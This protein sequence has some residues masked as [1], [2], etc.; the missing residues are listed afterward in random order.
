MENSIDLTTVPATVETFCQPEE[1]VHHDYSPSTLQSLEACPCWIGKQSENPHPRTVIGTL[2]HTVTETGEDD[3]KLADEDIEKVA[4]CIDFFESRKRL[5]IEA[6]ERSGLT[7]AAVTEIKE[8]YLP[9]DD[10]EFTD[11]DKKV[12]ATTAG[13][14]DCGI[15]THDKT[16]GEFFDWKFGMWPVE[17]AENNL[18]GIAYVLGAFRMF[19]Q[20]QTVRFWFKQPNIGVL[21]SHEFKR[22]N[23]GSLYLRVQVVVARARKARGLKDFSM[24]TPMIPACNFCAL[25]GECP[26]VTEFACKVGSKFYPLEIPSSITPS[27]VH[28][29]HD[30]RLGLA[31]AGVL[32]VWASA[33]K[34]VITDRVLRGDAPVPKGFAITQRTPREIV[35]EEKYKESALK[36]LTEAEYNGTLKPSFTKVEKKISEK[37]PRGQKSAEVEAFAAEIELN[38]AVKRG[39]SFSFLRACNEK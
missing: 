10:L 29:P 7:A 4:E 18:Q 12:K 15:L 13:Y 28:N 33:F 24:A 19:P 27:E 35:N 16:Y 14:I 30:T 22:E 11:G 3:P 36:R 39:D 34:G 32:A 37:A 21:T 17:K 1:R 5:A 23:I 8:T 38:G 26:K 9:I 25:I 6:A 31:L 2:S 20:L